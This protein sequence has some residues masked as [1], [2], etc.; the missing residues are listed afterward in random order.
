MFEIWK[1]LMRMFWRFKNAIQE[2][3]KKKF[4][5]YEIFQGVTFYFSPVGTI[6]ICVFFI[7][8]SRAHTQS[9]PFKSRSKFGYLS[10]CARWGPPR[11]PA[12][13]I[14]NRHSKKNRFSILL[15]FSYMVW[16][17][18]SSNIGYVRINVN[19]V[20]VHGTGNSF[21]MLIFKNFKKVKK[22]WNSYPDMA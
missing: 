1:M 20:F 22:K 8:E 2:K 19:R 4:K 18:S 16:I 7:T 5:K 21:P 15:I 10:K 17:L 12:T 11:P 6:W 9:Y 13:K 14:W 3:I